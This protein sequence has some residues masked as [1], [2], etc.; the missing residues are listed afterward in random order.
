MRCVVKFCDGSYINTAADR[1]EVLGNLLYVWQEGRLQAIADTGA[2]IE[3][4]LSER[5]GQD[6]A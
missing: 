2:I 6:N 4:H 1:M 3:A 5:G